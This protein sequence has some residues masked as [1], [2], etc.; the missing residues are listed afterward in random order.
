MASAAR[1][2]A[3]AGM[4]RDLMRVLSDSYSGADKLAELSREIDN[5]TA[6]VGIMKVRFGELFAVEFQLQPGTEALLSLRMVLQPIV[7]NSILHGFSG[8]SSGAPPRAGRGTI[9]V[10]ARLEDRPLP[11]AA[12]PEPWAEALPGKVLVMEVRD[13]GI[14]IEPDRAARIL[15]GKPDRGSLYRIGVANVHR[16]IRLNFGEPYGLQVESEPGVYTL[17]RYVLPALVRASQAE[18]ARA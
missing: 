11:P 18:A 13:D 2:D 12:C 7:E 14:G 3:I 5:V 15:E 1:A 10:A 8:G 16:R 9:R 17:V 4:T 6:Y